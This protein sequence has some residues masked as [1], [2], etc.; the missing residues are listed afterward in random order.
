MRLQGM[1]P[2][3]SVRINDDVWIGVRVCILPGVTI[4]E[5]TIGGACTVVSK[6]IPPYSVAVGN[7]MRIVK[8]REKEV[9]N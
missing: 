6:D 3:R 4:G 7:P 1:E 9:S 8:H 2:V 5:G